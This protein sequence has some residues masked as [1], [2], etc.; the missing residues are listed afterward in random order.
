MSFVLV[1]VLVVVLV[2]VV[3]SASLLLSSSRLRCRDLFDYVVDVVVA[4]VVV[5]VVAVSLVTVRP[6]TKQNEN[7]IIIFQ[8]CLFGLPVVVVVVVGDF[9]LLELCSNLYR[10]IPKPVQNRPP[11]PSTATNGELRAPQTHLEPSRRLRRAPVELLGAPKGCQGN[12]K[13]DPWELSGRV[14]EAFGGRFWFQNGD[15]SRKRCFMKMMLSL[16]REHRF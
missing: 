12:A 11:T 16:T 1:V 14:P 13:G 5:V 3:I 9:F 4:V 7:V 2:S 15:R 8:L 10:P 6:S